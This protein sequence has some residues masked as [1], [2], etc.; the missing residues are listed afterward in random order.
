MTDAHACILQIAQAQADANQVH[1]QV[2]L[3]RGASWV[4]LP[5][6][7]RPPARKRLDGIGAK[8]RPTVRPRTFCT[9]IAVRV[10][11]GNVVVTHGSERRA[12]WL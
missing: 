4:G 12:L 5:E 2:D 9:D 7:V 8:T 11:V 3:E 10:L 1:I 6:E